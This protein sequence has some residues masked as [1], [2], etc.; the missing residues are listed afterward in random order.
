VQVG[1]ESSTLEEL[2]RCL[3]GRYLL[4]KAEWKRSSWE[5]LYYR[6]RGGTAREKIG[7]VVVPA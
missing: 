7:R 5:A 6:L 2:L 3:C 1:R 4:A